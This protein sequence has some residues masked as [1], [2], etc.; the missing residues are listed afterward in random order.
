MTIIEHW[1]EIAAVGTAA[2]T[3]VKVF[4]PVKTVNKTRII[5][6]DIDASVLDKFAELFERIGTLEVDLKTTAEQLKDAVAEI[7]E[8]KKLEEYLKERLL[9][10]DVEIQ[11]LRDERAKNKGRIAALQQRISDLEKL[12]ERR[13][14]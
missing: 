11:S 13:Q 2:A 6:E 4:W 1:P 9:E 12:V 7:A 3:A 5:N 10:K 14:L 8:L